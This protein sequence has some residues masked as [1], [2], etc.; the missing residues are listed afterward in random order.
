MLG[1]CGTR[2][3]LAVSGGPDSLALL[4]LASD[5]PGHGVM[6]ATVDHG[7]R[8]ESGREAAEVA[9]ICARR[10]LNHFVLR[11][12]LQRG[13][14]L[15][16]RARDARYAAL[17]QWAR[18]HGLAAIATGHHADDQAETMIMRLNRGAG[19]RGLASMRPVAA[20]P[21]CSDITLLRPLLRWRKE[22]LEAV[23]AAQGIAACNDPSNRDDG[24]E[25]ARVRAALGATGLI[26]VDG[27][28]AS[29]G[30]L[31]EAD[32][33][34]EWAADMA[35]ATVEFGANDLVWR[36]GPPRAVALRVLERI[37]AIMGR[38]TPRGGALA[39]WHD[40]LCMGQVATLAGVRGDGRAVPW[41]FS[42]A[43]RHRATPD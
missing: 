19:L 7:L 5:V 21:G 6:V 10:A 13:P 15:Q 17:G 39:A 33:G 11:L 8:P 14:A 9:E 36:P 40:R 18:D 38:T 4:L 35:F 12:D 29:A 41:R 16:E 22:E 43:P 28:A 3:G 32:A 25:R 27:L 34:L 1:F 42:V 23:V 26:D 20:L 24:F 31:A 2:V 37:L 30:H